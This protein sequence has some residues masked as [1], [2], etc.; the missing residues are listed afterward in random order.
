[1]IPEFDSDGELPPGVHVATLDEVRQRFG[2]FSLTNRRPQLFTKLSELVEVARV[3]GIVDRLII[4]GSFVTAKAA[5]NDVDVLIIF[6]TE[7]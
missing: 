2:I 6:N 1:M 5:P 4:A 3:S 7:K